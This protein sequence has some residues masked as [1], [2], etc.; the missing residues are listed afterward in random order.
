MNESCG[1]DGN[2]WTIPTTWNGTTR[3]RAGAVVELR[4]LSRS[5]V[6]SE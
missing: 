3:K 4:S 1:A 2:S 6:A 5:P